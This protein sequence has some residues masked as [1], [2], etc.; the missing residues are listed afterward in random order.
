MT[1]LPETLYGCT[2][3]FINRLREYPRE[4]QDTLTEALYAATA[5]HA[6]QY[7]KSGLP[8]IIH[9]IQACLVLFAIKADV[10]SLVATLLHDTLEITS[11]TPEGI[12][13]RFGDDVYKLVESVTHN[14][15]FSNKEFLEKVY[16]KSNDDYRVACIKIADR[17]AN[18]MYGS[19]LVFPPDQHASNLRETEEFYVC[20]LAA[21]PTVPASLRKFLATCLEGS[22]HD[23]L[24]RHDN[25]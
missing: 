13:K 4:D 6:E 25:R 16:A 22:R 8:F 18:L 12:K 9:P 5:Y 11:A 20:Q 14:K 7:R 2:A 19:Q 21:L 23:L 1:P 24:T 15:I 3:A 17:C 10:P